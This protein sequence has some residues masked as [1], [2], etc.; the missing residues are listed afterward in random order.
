MTLFSSPSPAHLHLPLSWRGSGDK[1]HSQTQ[2]ANCT[3]RHTASRQR[4]VDSHSLAP[5]PGS[6]PVSPVSQEC[7]DNQ[8]GPADRGEERHI[9]VSSARVLPG[10]A[11]TSSSPSRSWNQAR[12]AHLGSDPGAKVS[13]SKALRTNCV[14][15]GWGLASLL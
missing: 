15:P 4:G 13:L 2:E 7:E 12:P 14:F 8:L 3:A 9:P 1:A 10:L 11:A 5:S 6:C